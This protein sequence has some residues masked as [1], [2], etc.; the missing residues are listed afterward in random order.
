MNTQGTFNVFVLQH[1]MHYNQGSNAG[2]L[3]QFFLNISACE[4][5]SRVHPV[6]WVSPVNPILKQGNT[7][8][9]H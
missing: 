7:D 6:T 2:Y 8:R 3:R 9:S 5:I 1:W 4:L